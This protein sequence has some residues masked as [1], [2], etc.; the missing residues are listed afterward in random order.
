MSDNPMSQ[1]AP[2]PAPAPTQDA[3]NWQAIY[4]D[5]STLDEFHRETAEPDAGARPEQ[6]A[7]WREHGFYWQDHGFAEVDQKRLHAFTLLPAPHRP[8]LPQHTVFVDRGAEAG[9]M[10]PIFFRRRISG[11]SVDGRIAV[12]MP[13]TVLGWQRT[14]GRGKAAKNVQAFVG[15]LDNG[16]SVV[17]ASRERLYLELNRLLMR[18]VDTIAAQQQ[19][20]DDAREAHAARN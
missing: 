5:G 1:P 14:I 16:S 3:W 12:A 20:E 6:H 17:A 9:N 10:R 8:D 13:V 15:Y 19:T 2:A 11:Q 4:D 7:H 18:V